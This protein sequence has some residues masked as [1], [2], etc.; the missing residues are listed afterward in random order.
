MVA[1]LPILTQVGYNLGTLAASYVVNRAFG[2]DARDKVAIAYEPGV[3]ARGVAPGNLVYGTA[4]VG[5]QVCYVNVESGTVL[6]AKELSLVLAIAA[7]ECEAFRSLRLDDETLTPD[8]AGDPGGTG[9]VAS[10]KFAG[11]LHAIAH[12]GSSTQAADLRLLARFSQDWS[13]NHQG[14][15]VAYAVLTYALTK[16]TRDLWSAG[17][18]RNIQVQ[19]DG[20][21]CYDPR[22]GDPDVDTIPGGDMAQY[23]AHTSNPALCLADYIIHPLGLDESP[24]RIIWDSVEDLADHCDEQVQTPHSGQTAERFTCNGVLSTAAPHHQNLEA[25][26]KSGLASLVYSGGKYYML[27]FKSGTSVAGPW[28]SD[29]Q[30]QRISHEVDYQGVKGRY[31]GL[32]GTRTP[33]EF[34]AVRATGVTTGHEDLVVD[35]GMTT[36]HWR[37]ERIAFGLVRAAQQ[38]LIVTARADHRSLGLTPGDRIKLTSDRF[39]WTD[40]LFRVIDLTWQVQDG[41]ELV[42]REDA[43]SVYSDPSTAQYSSAAAASRVTPSAGTVAPPS[44]LSA[45][46]GSEYIHLQW[47]LPEIPDWDEIVLYVSETDSW[48]DATELWRGQGESYQYGPPTS[49]T[50]YYYWVRA[51]VG[52]LE[53]KRDPDSDT[54]TV[55]AQARSA[56]IAKPVTGGVALP[57]SID[58]PMHLEVADDVVWSV[59]RF[60]AADGGSWI[61]VRTAYANSFTRAEADFYLPTGDIN[62]VPTT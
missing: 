8:W 53:S 43:S 22:E 52:T 13:A 59:G 37:A 7:H 1:W 11:A 2:D 23:S 42:L 61:L 44:G 39:G 9:S 16:S 27:P 6:P 5:G 50:D 41:A 48:A 20:R 32:G 17:P 49:F 3:T 62:D 46:G 38:A 10:G 36:E 45:V 24:T 25:V 21:E 18:P 57:F 19:V 51:V 60:E 34:P 40:K 33:A 14:Q 31:G 30:I 47:T 55:T 56:G 54:S 58:D 12:L 35:L 28:V 15:D 29:D 4:W 26:Q